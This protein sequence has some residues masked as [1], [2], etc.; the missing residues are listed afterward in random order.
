MNKSRVKEPPST[1]VN[2]GVKS[3]LSWSED[4]RSPGG[5]ALWAN[6]E[7]KKYQVPGVK[8]GGV[9]Q[10]VNGDGIKSL[11]KEIRFHKA[12]VERSDSAH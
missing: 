7:S 1:S 8:F 5:A 9:K 10:G 11:T 4:L 12:P 3:A 6:V 2:R